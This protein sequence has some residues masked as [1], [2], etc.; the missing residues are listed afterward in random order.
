MNK[1]QKTEERTVTMSAGFPAHR[2][3][4]DGDNDTG[5]QKES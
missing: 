4:G 5:F 3:D 1:R 2:Y